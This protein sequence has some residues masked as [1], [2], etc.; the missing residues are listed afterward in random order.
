MNAVQ[1]ANILGFLGAGIG[2]V[3]FVP[4]AIK[5][6]KTKNTNSISL[7]SF[8]LFAIASLFWT[9]YGLLLNALPIIIV[10]IVLLVLN[11][12]IVVMKIKYG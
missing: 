7:F 12:F 2:I 4:Q 1:V 11:F 5:V 10:N 8:I 3:M 9:I 6:Y